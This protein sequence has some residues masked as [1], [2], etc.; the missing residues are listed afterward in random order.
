MEAGTSA[1]NASSSFLCFDLGLNPA[2]TTHPADVTSWGLARDEDLGEVS[3]VCD[4][5]FTCGCSI[6]ATTA[7]TSAPATS[8]PVGDDDGAVDEATDG[9]AAFGLTTGGTFLVMALSS[10]V[11]AVANWL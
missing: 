7:P 8:M 1:G 5:T 2:E 6:A 10:A 11:L 3:R 4:I 9:D